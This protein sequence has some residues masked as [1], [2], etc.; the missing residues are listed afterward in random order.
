MDNA[1]IHRDIKDLIESTGAKLIYTAPYSP[2]LNPIELM[3]GSYKPVLHRHNNEPWDRAL[4]YGL[5]SVTPDIARR[6]CSNC[7][8]TVRTNMFGKHTISRESEVC[9]TL[10]ER[11]VHVGRAKGSTLERRGCEVG[12]EASILFGHVHSDMFDAS[13]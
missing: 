7:A 2:D 6:H 11:G 10:L 13:N 12:A 5:T 3:F 8:Q 1:S 9:Y 4:N